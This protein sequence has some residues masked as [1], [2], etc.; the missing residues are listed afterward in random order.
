M[1][2]RILRSTFRSV[3]VFA[4][5]LCLIAVVD[6]NR[7]PP[8]YKEFLNLPIEHQRAKLR[9][10]PIDKQIDYYLAATSY[11]H[12]PELELGDIIASE[13]KEAVPYL[14][15][16]LGEEKQEHRQISLMYV[17]EHMNRFDYNLK[18]EGE[19]LDLLKEV[20]ANMTDHKAEAER[21]LGDILENRPVDLKKFKEDHP[22]Y[23]PPH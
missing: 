3:G 4:S 1:N 6:C 18:D 14:V 15:K 7:T 8:E 16:R 19:T 11:A 13:G 12:P 23:F 17:F 22:E 5:V 20:V 2:L 9:T 21:V 10:F